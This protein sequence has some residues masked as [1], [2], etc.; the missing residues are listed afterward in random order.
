MD[1]QD[2]FEQI[3]NNTAKHLKL[4]FK[5]VTLNV[6]FSGDSTAVFWLSDNNK[7]PD[8]IVTL[9]Y[10][11][12]SLISRDIALECKVVAHTLHTKPDSII[13]EYELSS[14]NEFFPN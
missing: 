8:S 1:N 14:K 4:S 2:L 11:L 13:I 9:P 12:I 6:N 10:S 3:N 5:F 7:Q